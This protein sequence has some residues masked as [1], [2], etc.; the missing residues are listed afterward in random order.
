LFFNRRIF[1][2]HLNYDSIIYRRTSRI[3]LFGLCTHQTG[4]ILKMNKAKNKKIVVIVFAWIAALLMLYYVYI[5][6][7]I[8]FNF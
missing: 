6:A 8:L 4:K 7:K 5:K 3:W 1:R 2:K